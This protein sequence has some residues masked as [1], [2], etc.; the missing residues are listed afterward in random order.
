MNPLANHCECV[1]RG[2]AAN[3]GLTDVTHLAEQLKLWYEERKTHREAM[4]DYEAELITRGREAG[5]LNRQ[6]CLDAHD[7][8]NLRPNSPLTNRSACLT[9]AVSDACQLTELP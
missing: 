7:I 8:Q 5:L 2:E 1:V 4:A 3:H 6:A 9:S